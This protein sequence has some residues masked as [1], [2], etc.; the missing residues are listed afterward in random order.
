MASYD[1]KI[2]YGKDLV[3]YGQKLVDKIKGN[4]VDNL[5][6]NETNKFLSANQGKILNETK[7]GKTEKAENS[8]LSDVSVRLQT[9]RNIILTGGV[10]GRASFDGTADATITTTL[11]DIDASKI[12]SGTIDID[13]LPKGAIPDLVVVADDLAR[14]ALTKDNVQNGDTVKVTQTLKMYFVKD[15]NQLSTEAGYEEY[16]AGK[17]TAVDWTGIQGKPESFPPSAHN[18]A[19][20]TINAM[21]GYAKTGSGAIYPSDSLNVAIGK[22]EV[23]LDTKEPTISKQSGFNLPKSD[24]INE[25]NSSQLATSLAVKTAYDKGMDALNK[26]TVVEQSVGSKLDKSGYNGTANDLKNEIDGKLGRTEKANSATTAD[27]CTGNSATATKLQ[28]ARTING[29]SFDGTENIQINTQTTRFRPKISWRT[30][31]SFRVFKTL[32]SMCG[33]R[34]MGID[35]KTG[36]EFYSVVS[37]QKEN[38]FVSQCDIDDTIIN[39]SAVPTES[40]LGVF[41]I[42]QNDNECKIVTT[43]F[44]QVKSI[45]GTT[46]TVGKTKE[47]TIG[48]ESLGVNILGT[49]VHKK[50]L[51]IT[52]NNILSGRICS[53]T[54][55]TNDTIDVDIAGDIRTGDTLLVAPSSDEY[56]YVGSVY[57]DTHE[58]RNRSDDGISVTSYGP[59]MTLPSN[60]NNEITSKNFASPL[61]NGVYF[62]SQVQSR[63]SKIGDLMLQS[64]EDDAHKITQYSDYKY[65][66][67]SV[68]IVSP[69]CYQS[70]GYKNIFSVSC[71]HSLG[72]NNDFEFR[73]IGFKEV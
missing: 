31:R 59:A 27:T 42:K 18:Q 12:T 19:S 9:S 13:R 41:V 20:N 61:A 28:T 67:V 22:L 3:P 52:E 58:L 33:F 73:I 2:V 16:T 4:I 70:F 14:F 53:V 44:F 47:N 66:S 37:S 39:V 63:N 36:E 21:T 45:S 7:L 1:E 50:V 69:R 35:E 46:I 5:N 30:G 6:S 49:V 38:T 64:G 57:V 60:Q 25:A 26:V 51:V 17:A 56:E 54:S 40:W 29:V 62:Y 11:S 15:D 43:P 71:Y 68:D 10:S 8:K 34:F 65:S 72:D 48:E 55:N 32:F 23:A 24:A